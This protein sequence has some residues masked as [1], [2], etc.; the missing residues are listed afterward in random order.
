MTGAEMKIAITGKGGVGKTTIAASLARHYAALGKKVFAIDADP[1]ANLANALGMDIERSGTLTPIS[2]MKNLVLERTG[3]QPGTIGGF[4]KL[5]PQVD[6]LP[7]AIAVDIDGVKL[8]VMGGVDHAGHGCVCPE[9]TILRSLM[10]H[11]VVDRDEVV[12]MDMEAGIEHFGRSTAEA[13]DAFIVV[14]EPGMRSIQTAKT[15]ATLAAQIGVKKVFLVL[16]KLRDPSEELDM[17][18]HLPDLPILGTIPESA[19]I[20]KAD[21]SG[22]SP[23]DSDGAVTETISQLAKKLDSLL[24]LA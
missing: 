2:E 20:R 15:V 11:L 14:V 19:A 1:D 21:L 16:N 6:D 17:A 24:N 5:N 10:R 18:A 8:L 13:V 4:F 12:I 23:Y 22:L 7:E 3:A 9:S